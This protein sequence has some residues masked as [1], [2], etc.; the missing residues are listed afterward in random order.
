MPAIPKFDIS[1]LNIHE[2]PIPGAGKG[3]AADASVSVEYKYPFAFV[4][5]PLGFD[6]LVR[7]CAPDQPNLLL[8]DATTSEI[9]VVPNHDVTVDVG[10]VIRD[11]PKELTEACPGS[12]TSP[13]DMLVGDYIQGLDTTIFVRGS[14]SPSADTP[15]WISDLTKSITV[16][17]PFPGRQQFGDLIKNFTMTNVHFGLPDPFA[18]PDT[19]EAQP[20]FSALLKVL[21]G[22]PSEMNFS[23]DV[24]KIR[25]KADVFYHGDKLGYLDLHK[26][27]KAFAKRVTDDDGAPGL[28]I[29]ADV[30]DAPLQVTNDDVFTEVVQRLL[31]GGKGV[32]LLVKANVDAQT[33]TALG[34]FVVRDIPAEGEVEVN[35]EFLVSDTLASYLQ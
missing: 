19:P 23:L 20:K 5:P 27:Q 33:D 21:V 30:Q 14:N 10:G 29:E 3:M 2:V 17:L 31:F 6:I 12:K 1:K 4:V 25:T 26:W 22:L 28:L 7:N 13:L 8:A 34:N 9:N 32:T 11:L 15:G 18:D 35:R 16:P 24:S